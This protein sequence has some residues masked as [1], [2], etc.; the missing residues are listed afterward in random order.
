M[1]EEKI[2]IS[3][4]L[5]DMYD[6][7]GGPVSW[8]ARDYYYTNH[9]TSEEQ[10]QMDKEEKFQTIFAFSVMIGILLLCVVMVISYIF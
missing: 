2:P 10:M 1:T 8:A 7:D 9:A 3:Q 6:P 5:N 4:V